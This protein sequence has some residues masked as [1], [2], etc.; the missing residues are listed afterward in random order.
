MLLITFSG[1]SRI[2]LLKKPGAAYV[3]NSVC[4]FIKP[5][6]GLGIRKKMAK[7]TKGIISLC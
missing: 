5:S 3:Y 7:K 2:F 6:G 1:L 4:F